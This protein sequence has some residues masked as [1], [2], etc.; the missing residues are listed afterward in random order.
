MTDTTTAGL[1]RRTLLSGAAFGLVAFSAAGGLAGCSSG[2]TAATISDTVAALPT[3]VPIT[4]GPKPD[5]PGN[6]VVQPVYYSYPQDSELFTSVTG[7]V[8]DGSKTSGFVVTYTAPPPADNSFLDYIGSLTNTEYDLTFVP[9]DSFDTK[10]AT[11]TAGNDIPDIVEFLTFAMPPRFPQLLDAKFSDLSEYLSGDAVKDY[12]NLANIPT[13]SWRSAR[14]NGKIYGVPEHRPPFGSVMVCRP[15]LIEQLT[16]AAPAPKDKDEFTE[17]CRAVTDTKAGRYAIAGGGGSS[18]VDWSYDFIGATFGVPNQ[19]KQSSG[20][21]LTHKNETG[22]WLE[23]LSYIKKLWNL[24]IYHP[25]T[26]SLESAK[27]KTYINNGTVLMHLD[28]ISALLDV[29]MPKGIVTGGIV[30]F[31]A[32]GGKGANYQGTSSF[33]FAALKKTTPARIRSQLRLLDYLSAPF[34]SR[35]AFT[36]THGKKNVHHTGSGPDAVLTKTGEQMI[37]ASS[38]YRLAAGPQ[39]LNTAVRI[40]EQLRQS[41]AWQ[42]ATQDMLVKNPVDGFYSPSATSTQ[43]ANQAFNSVCNDYVLG[44]TN[45]TAVKAGVKTWTAAAGDKM[46]KEYSEAMEKQG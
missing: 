7:K 4:K 14:I 45:L 33:S 32:D 43:S 3:Y 27:A 11:M 46:R 16:G 44:R 20:G 42:V 40:D 41:H 6:D 23:M 12:P 21:T 22:A 9:G 13:A 10:F 29:T 37:N 31:G 36:L 19:W 25:D 34:G 2:G 5:L 15:D 38:L 8:A 18:G 17:L 26:P 39:V 35:E 30:P 28:G 24:G 1:S